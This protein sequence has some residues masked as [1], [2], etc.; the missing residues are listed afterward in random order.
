MPSGTTVQF[1]VELPTVKRGDHWIARAGDKELKLTNLNKVFWPE[2]GY[3]KGDLLTYYFN[4]SPT[5]LPHIK[6]RPLTLKRMPDGVVG[7]YFYEKNAPSYRPKWMTTIPV[8]S[9]GENKIINF[10]SACDVAEMLWVVNLGCIEFHPLHSRGP[11]QKRPDYAFFDLDP[12]QPAGYDEVKHV[13]ALVKLL[14]DKLGLRSYPKTSGATG[15]Q[16]MVPL[17]GTHNYDEVRGFVGTISDMIHAADPDTTTLEWEVRKR[18]G[19][20]FLDVNMNREGAN[21]AAAYSVRPEWGA[22]CSA[23]FRW[24]ELADIQPSLF[25]IETMFDR[26]ADVG[27]PFLEVAEGPGQSLTDAIAEIGATPRKARE[28]K[29]R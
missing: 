23:P 9:E 1:P 15:M 16:I 8:Y 18:T 19:K 20:V 2:N 21:I 17:D 14:L 27:D 7:A 5:M 22:T 24:D 26:V 10:L 3:T 13:A 4:I 6:A 25:T 29:T 11:E 12:F 28:I